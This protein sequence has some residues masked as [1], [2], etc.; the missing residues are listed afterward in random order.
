[1]YDVEFPVGEDMMQYAY[2]ISTTPITPET[3]FQ[4]NSDKNS[5]VLSI[6]LT[7]D[8][9]ICLSCSQARY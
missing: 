4:A 7:I 6:Y 1:M 5:S 9:I 3:L 2:P 8:T